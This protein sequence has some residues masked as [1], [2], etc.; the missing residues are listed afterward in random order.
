VVTFDLSDLYASAH[1]DDKGRPMRLYEK[2]ARVRRDAAFKPSGIDGLR[3]FGVDYSGR[4]GAP[5]L[6]VVAD[7]IA[8]GNAKVWCWRLK[9]EVVEPKTKTVKAPGDLAATTIDGNTVTVTKPDGAT[10]R[11]TFVAP[12]RAE[13]TAEKRSITYTKTYNRGEGQ[14]PAPGIYAS[15]ANPGDGQFFVIATIKQGTPP[16]VKVDGS[17]LEAVVTVGKQTVCFDGE[18]IVFG[19]Q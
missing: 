9:D 8:G 18:K 12:Q 1:K 3:S 2:Y 19:K 17:G 13:I 15:G 7:R 5:C 14:M 11:L 16:V 6:F 10:I 4:S